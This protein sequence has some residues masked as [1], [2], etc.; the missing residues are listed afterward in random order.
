[1]VLILIEVG[2]WWSVTGGEHELYM[3]TLTVSIKKD[4]FDTGR[5]AAFRRGMVLVGQ[6]A[7]N[8]TDLLTRMTTRR[9]IVQI[10]RVFT[11]LVMGGKTHATTPIMMTVMTTIKAAVIKRKKG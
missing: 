3:N 6:A 9:A 11:K 7:M 10:R 2:L 5:N 4:K 1:M 8:K